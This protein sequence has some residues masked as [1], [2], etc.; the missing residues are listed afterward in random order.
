MEQTG[1]PSLDEILIRDIDLTHRPY[2]H[3][4]YQP[5][6]VY[7]TPVYSGVLTCSIYV[8]YVV[9]GQVNDI[10]NNELSYCCSVN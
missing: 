10:T 2:P 3:I 5:S 7:T 6:T 1:L 4:I 8:V 9:Y